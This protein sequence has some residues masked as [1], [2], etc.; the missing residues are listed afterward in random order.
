MNPVALRATARLTLL[1]MLAALL[2]P[3]L[4]RAVVGGGGGTWAEIC[5]AQGPKRVP[6][7]ADGEVPLSL[8]GAW[9]H[10]PWCLKLDAAPPPA[11]VGRPEPWAPG[12][13]P[14]PPCGAAAA[15]GAQPWP[16]PPSRG[17]PVGRVS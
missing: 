3:A 16:A 1:A 12:G 9:D 8:H 17:P 6:E 10:C 14:R 2:L 5:T 4:A 15:A 13:G 7:V 11:G